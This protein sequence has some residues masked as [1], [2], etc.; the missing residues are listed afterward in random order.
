M[1]KTQKYQTP[2]REL[3]YFSSHGFSVHAQKKTTTDLSTDSEKLAEMLQ[4]V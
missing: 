2:L 3:N 1:I 4:Y